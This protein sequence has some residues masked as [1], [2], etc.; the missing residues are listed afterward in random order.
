MKISKNYNEDDLLS[1]VLLLYFA[2]QHGSIG[3]FLVLESVVTLREKSKTLD[4]MAWILPMDI[5]GII[6]LVSAGAFLFSVLQAGKAEY[7][8][9]IIAGISGGVTFGFLSMASM[10]LSVN[11]TNTV[12]YMIIAS[13]DMIVAIVG[14][15]ALWRR[16]DL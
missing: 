1:K 7:W 12:N 14:G 3:L 15:V 8:L 16:K 5:W 13:I 11:Q 9:M 4:A 2:F 10:E 6:L